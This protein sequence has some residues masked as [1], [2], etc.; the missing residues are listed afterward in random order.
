M[1]KL[2]KT[3]VQ[4]RIKLLSSYAKNPDDS[5]AE[6]PRSFR[7]FQDRK[8]IHPSPSFVLQTFTEYAA[9]HGITDKTGIKVFVGEI[10][11]VSSRTIE[12]WIKEVDSNGD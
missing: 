12:R 5:L 11:G 9:R 3:I 1:E 6:L 2:E 4:Q 8:Y 10:C 7:P